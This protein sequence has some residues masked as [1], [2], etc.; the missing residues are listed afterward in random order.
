MWSGLRFDP[1]A[2]GWPEVVLH[3]RLGG[4]RGNVESLKKYSFALNFW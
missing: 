2:F 4:Q 1:S 3:D